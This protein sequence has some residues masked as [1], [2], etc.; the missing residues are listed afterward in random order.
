LHGHDRGEGVMVVGGAHC[1]GVDVLADLVEHLAVIVELLSAREFLLR[2]RLEAGVVNVANGDHVAEILGVAR[3]A[4]PFAGNSDAGKANGLV[5]RETLLR[6]D[7]SPRPQANSYGGGFL[8]KCSASRLP[9]HCIRPQNAE[10]VVGG[11][12]DAAR[13]LSTLTISFRVRNPQRVN[14]M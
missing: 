11:W 14:I 4:V 10:N 6:E 1:H 8:Q 9:R 3:V 12:P 13:V 7:S 2:D 5:R